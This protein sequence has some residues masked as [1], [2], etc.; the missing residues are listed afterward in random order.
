MQSANRKNI[1]ILDELHLRL[2]SWQP[3][4]NQCGP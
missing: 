1:L 3:V 2:S 4:F